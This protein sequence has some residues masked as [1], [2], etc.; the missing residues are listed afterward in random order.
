[1]SG[2]KNQINFG[3]G[4]FGDETT[5]FKMTF[6]GMVMFLSLIIGLGLIE[7]IGAWKGIDNQAALKSLN[8]ESPA[9]IRNFIRT[10][11]LIN[12]L[13]TF[14]IPAIA[15][16]YFFYKSKWTSYLHIYNKPNITNLFLGVVIILAAFPLAQFALWLNMK[17][18][19]PAALIETETQLAEMIGN[20]L[21]V[22]EPY[23]LYFNLFIIAVI[24][25]IGEEF[26]FRGIIQKKLV[27]IFQNYHLGIWVAA[28]IFSAFHMQFQGFLPRVVLGAILGYLFVWS[29]NL[30]VPIFAH[31]ANNA[32][33]IV[34]QYFYQLGKIEYDFNDAIVD[35]NWGMTIVSAIII[36]MLGRLMIIN[37]QNQSINQNQNVNQNQKL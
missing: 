1:M 22:K 34:G 26:I 31:F 25:A 3:A 33:Q 28:I 5:F 15:F 2:E 23:E 7:A 29:G 12:H 21:I 24:P 8:A 4:K 30:W 11:L 35:V 32:F 18:P 6:L 16:S 9:N 27:E 37:N 19:L 36:I 10:N 14:I 13:T 20:L 17:I